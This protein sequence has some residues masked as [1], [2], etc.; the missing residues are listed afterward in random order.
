FGKLAG[1][2]ARHPG[3]PM[4]VFGHADPTGDPSYNKILS[5]R[6]ARSVFAVMTKN[7]DIWEDL[8]RNQQG[9]SGDDWG[10]RSLQMMLDAL[11]HQPGNMDGKM[12]ERTREAI[13]ELLGLPPGTP[14]NSTTAIRKEIFARY[15]DFL[16]A[17]EDG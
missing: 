2:I 8:F 6:R 9:A 3:S 17:G 11:G 13:R 15:M 12:D 16:R 7:T 1:V 14:V 5:E 4:S 10:T